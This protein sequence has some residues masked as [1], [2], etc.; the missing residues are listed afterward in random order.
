MTE[1]IT[2]ADALTGMAEWATGGIATLSPNSTYGEIAEKAKLMFEAHKIL[3]S[4]H[5]IQNDANYPTNVKDALSILMLLA[6][7]DGH[8]PGDLSQT[9][10]TAWNTIDMVPSNLSTGM[11]KA[12]FYAD[13]EAK[14]PDLFVSD[15]SGGL[16]TPSLISSPGTGPDYS[17]IDAA[18][19]PA[20]V[21]AAVNA[22][23]TPW[24]SAF[25]EASPL[26]LDL[27]SSH[28]GIALTTFNASTTTTFFDIDNSGFATQT[29]WVGADMGLLC[30][31]LNANGRIDNA[32][33]LFGSST[34]D[35]FALLSQLDSNGD[36]RID[37][38]DSAWST[39]KIWVDTNGDA[40]TQSGELH[41]MADLGVASIDLAAVAASTSTISGNPIS[42]TS[43]FTFTS[44]TTAAI[45]DA[46]F[47][48]DKVNSYYTGN[49]TLDVDT[50]FLPTLRGF[51]TLPDL[52]ISESQDSTLKALV[53]DFTS[54]FDPVTAFADPANLNGDIE[55]ILYRW[56]GVNGV[57]PTSRG[58]NI[59]GQHLGFMEMFFGQAF[60]QHGQFI[61]TNPEA[62]AGDDLSLSWQKMFYSLKA[63]LLIQAG[64]GDLFGDSAAYNPS[65][66]GIEGN[67][68]ISQTAID[69]LQAGAPTGA[70]AIEAYWGQVA[71]FVDTV[72]GFANLTSSENTMLDNAIAATDPSLSWSTDK[73]VAYADLPSIGG[74]GI[75]LY[76]T[77]GAES[78]S[79]GQGDDL[80]YGA[81]GN[82]TLQG[83]AGNDR[84]YG[85]DGDDILD[86]GVGGNFVNG[87]TGNDTFIFSGGS[88]VY[89]ESYGG[90]TDTVVLPSGITLNDLTFT[91]VVENG[92]ST[93][94]MV[95]VGSDYDFLVSNFF[96]N[97]AGTI[98]PDSAN[99]ETLTFSDSTTYTLTSM[100][101]INVEGS[102]GND[103]IHGA[104]T[105]GHNIDSTIHGED[106]DDLIYTG[107]GTNIIDGGAGNDSVHG[108]TG[109]DTYVMSPGF[110]KIYDNTGTNILLMPDSI[111][112]DDIHLLRHSQAANDLEVMVDGFGQVT[113]VGQFQGATLDQIQLHD[114]SS[115]TLADQSVETVGTTGND[116][117]N[118]IT[119]GGSIDDILDGREGNDHLS[120]AYGNDT[121]VF[122]SGNDTY[123]E[124]AGTDKIYIG[125][126]W[127]PSDITMYREPNNSLVI[128]DT[129]GNSAE[130]IQQFQSAGSSIETI[131]FANGTTWNLTTMAIEAHGTSG[132]D[133]FNP[134]AFG[135]QQLVIY[136]YDGADSLHSGTSD[137]QLYGGNGNDQL[138]GQGGNDIL[139]GGDGNDALQGNSGDDTYIFSTGN[140]TVTDTGGADTLFI[141][142]D[143]TSADITL[144]RS[145]NGSLVV[146]DTVG[147]VATVQGEFQSTNYSIE[148]IEFSDSTI[149][150]PLTMAMEVHGTSGNDGITPSALGNQQLVIY[151]YDGADTLNAGTSD[152]Q[153]YGGDG[154]DTLNGKAGNDILYGGD[155][156]DTLSGG[157][158]A[159]TFGF[160]TGETGSDTI[161]GFSTAQ[162]DKIDIHDVLVGYDPL[163]DAIT[164]YVH[165]TASGSNA[166]LS[167][168]ANG[169]AGGA[170]FTQIATIS[171][172]SSLAGHEADMLANGYLI[173]QAA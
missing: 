49:Y 100:T 1:F 45:D 101:S 28:T 10:A 168:D 33:E 41:T 32:G 136:G 7:F 14:Y 123:S 15:G 25:S 165:V 148:T 50:L 139:D 20:A 124:Q 56:A 24:N 66:G 169:A 161:S 62:I 117:L 135:N 99:I 144:Y 138:S 112:V 64:G 143:W 71:Q 73:A 89:S 70:T 59:D 141:G 116:T 149:W 102:S 114:N 17:G 9:F 31:D 158:G 63:D 43:F 16:L 44:G 147:N 167:V 8:D 92:Y 96:Y 69:A 105:T 125:D 79:G 42:H 129:S 37:Q 128:H 151:G 134:T 48:H 152:S 88:D 160:L 38:Y 94:L 75:T 85:E 87:G 5:N 54:G 72:K 53:S 133:T 84:L 95:S 108:G 6:P 154:N 18:H 26:V 104:N 65:A 115:I 142:N 121:Y 86:P 47:V 52:A 12:D 2:N 109:D 107:N 30:R 163:T 21:P 140:D 97:T 36:H 156:S 120:G 155:G 164:D 146:Q 122:S 103:Y 119:L 77:A 4:I 76:G 61:E 80:L 3:Q 55:D 172:L 132:N 34:V 78:I 170:G 13:L 93:G 111:T 162:G 166:I 46:W 173:A 58:G 74:E 106:G 118:G 113:A 90:G 22:A 57:A 171:G 51:G 82:D 23:E 60:V 153:L 150:H 19:I 40:V 27:T 131:E 110:D 126:G 98:M 29:A 81:G 137:S 39:L 11:S 67:K 130:I 91:Q 127:S 145:V 68:D 35:G 159:D 157:A 83:Y